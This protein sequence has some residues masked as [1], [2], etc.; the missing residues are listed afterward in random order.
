MD[1]DHRAQD[2][3]ERIE[4]MKQNPI[5][6]QVIARLEEAVRNKRP[7]RPMLIGLDR[8]RALANEPESESC[9]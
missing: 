7:V 2:F 8:L 6:T 1:T 5:R 4:Q 3:E 9:D